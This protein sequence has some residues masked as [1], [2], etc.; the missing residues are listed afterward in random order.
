MNNTSAN[1]KLLKTSAL[2]FIGNFSA[3]IL[4]FL[5]VPLYTS[6]LTVSSYGAID[7]VMTANQI[8]APILS[9]QITQGMF[10]F[11]IDCKTEDEK[12]AVI[13]SSFVIILLGSAA[14]CI[15]M[16]PYALYVGSKEWLIACPYIILGMINGYVIQCTRG[17]KKNVLY[18]TTSLISSFLQVASNF[19]FI[20][21]LS[22][23][24]LSLLLAPILTSV[25][26]IIILLLNKRMYGLFTFKYSR[27]DLLFSITRFSIPTIPASLVWWGMSGFGKFYLSAVC[28]TAAVG[29][30]SMSNK[31]SDIITVIYSV[32]NMAW[33][34]VA[35]ETFRDNERDKYYSGVYNSL[36]GFLLSAIIVGIPL[37]KII[38]PY[39]IKGE[40]ASAYLYIP[41]MYI[42]CFF[43]II[44]SFLTSLFNAFKKTVYVVLACLPGTITNI[45]LNLILTKSYGVF[46]TVT[47][48]LIGMIVYFLGNL[49]YAKKLCQIAAEK[50]YGLLFIPLLV[51]IGL[52]YIDNAILQAA[53]VLISLTLFL[54]INRA[55]ITSLQKSIILKISSNRRIN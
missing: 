39:F 40:F 7:L 6:L 54:I 55:L 28:G 37:T 38:S 20:V 3:K 12:K 53:L 44:G 51:N 21:G 1:N 35:Y 34:E 8:L 26:S 24:S 27:K 52:Y 29:L 25:L 15:T 33:T 30:F 5:L 47:A 4:S 2:Y 49:Y 16:I 36:V 48:L 41:I 43:S 31:F 13:S 9:L 42:M 11:L 23:G 45:I 46:G 22:L 18:A 17:L 10:R 50:K 19:I 14:L 32:F